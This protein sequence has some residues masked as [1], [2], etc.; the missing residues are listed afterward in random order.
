MENTLGIVRLAVKLAL[1]GLLAIAAIHL[2]QRLQ[3]GPVA[4]LDRAKVELL[5][6]RPGQ[7]LPEPPH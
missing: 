5:A 1:A 4:G 2:A 3:R 7:P 6:W